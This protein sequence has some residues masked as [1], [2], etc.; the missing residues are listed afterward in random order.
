MSDTQQEG[1]EPSPEAIS[2]A[3]PG[4]AQATAAVENELQALL[5][6]D[7]FVGVNVEKFPFRSGGDSGS[8]WRTLICWPGLL[9][10]QAWFL[11]R[12][13]YGWAA[14][15]GLLPIVAVSFNLGEFKRVLLFAPSLIGLLGRRIYMDFAGRTVARI[16][17]SNDREDDARDNIH[18][19][20]GVSIAGAII[21][22]FIVVGGGAAAFLAGF[23]VGFH[24][25]LPR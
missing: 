5:D 23:K 13:L 1:E 15:C 7:L 14:L 10:P 12:K 22:A 24:A 21:G 17:A 8:R 18:R 20:G 4:E 2:S 9:F 19:A 16:R 6:F 3:R 11:Y 25:G